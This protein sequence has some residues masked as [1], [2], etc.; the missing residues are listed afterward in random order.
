MGQRVVVVGGGVSDLAAAQEV[1]ARDFDAH[2][3]GRLA[4]FGGKAAVVGSHPVARTP[5]ALAS[6]SG[7][8]A[9]ASFVD[10]IVSFG[11]RRTVYRLLHA[12][13]PADRN[14]MTQTV[15][16]LPSAGTDL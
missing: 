3:D 13:V 8:V 10:G 2:A 7:R 15:C 6:L 1:I 12:R 5:S 4:I 11:L 9:S 14:A 16:D